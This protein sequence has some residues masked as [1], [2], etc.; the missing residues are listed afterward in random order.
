MK[1][2][3]IHAVFHTSL[4][5]IYISDNNYLYLGQLDEQVVEPQQHPTEWAAEKIV[6]Y[7]GLGTHLL[8]KVLW[9]SVDST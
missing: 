7:P 8:F 1:Q 9:K 3:A 6:S 5:R 2:C 4:L